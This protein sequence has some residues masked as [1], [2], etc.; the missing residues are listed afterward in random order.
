MLSSLLFLQLH[1]ALIFVAFGP[2]YITTLLSLLLGRSSR[3]FSTSAPAVLRAYCFL[4]PFLGLNGV[5]EAFVQAVA[6]EKQLGS[7]RR[8]MV[9]WSAVFVAAT[10]VG[11][12][13]MIPSEVGMVAA[14][15]ITM[16]C[17]IVW[18][19]AFIRRFF[20]EAQTQ[21]PEQR[22]ALQQATSLA[23]FS[24]N[25]WTAAAFAIA[26]Q[27]VRISA[28]RTGSKAGFE[29]L[30]AHLAVGAISGAICILVM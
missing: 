23:R 14:T 16:A 21:I 26:A 7:M 9:L 3:Y 5:I 12:K 18:G 2:P 19:T 30:L 1:L 8:A 6:T 29:G 24:P 27:V 22:V 17:R 25:R 15:G 4:L 10:W 13:A 28:Q 11:T 20:K